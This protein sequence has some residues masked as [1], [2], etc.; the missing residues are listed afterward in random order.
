MLRSASIGDIN[1][2]KKLIRSG[3]DINTIS[4]NGNTPLMVASS[5]NH[6]DIVKLLVQAGA[7]LDLQK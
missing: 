4:S 7:K 6:V 2:I 3:S 5:N 1:Q